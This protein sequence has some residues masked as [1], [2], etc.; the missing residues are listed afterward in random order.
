MVL[1]LNRQDL[2]PQN[3]PCSQEGILS[4]SILCRKS[5]ELPFWHNPFNQCSQTIVLT[6]VSW[7]LPEPKPVDHTR[8]RVSKRYACREGDEEVDMPCSRQGHPLLRTQKE[9]TFSIQVPAHFLDFK[10]LR[11]NLLHLT[12]LKIEV[13]GIHAQK[14]G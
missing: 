8:N 7:K 11:Q 6:F 4:L 5:Q 2:F 10:R 12:S 1:C 13:N 14:M 3:L 9:K